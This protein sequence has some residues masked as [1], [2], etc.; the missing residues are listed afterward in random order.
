M[1]NQDQRLRKIWMQTDIPVIFRQERPEPTLVRLPFSLDNYHWLKGEHRRKPDWDKK[2]KCWETPIAWFD[3]LITISLARFNRVYV[4]QA[5]KE[6]QKCAPA[7][8]NAHGFHCECS[9]MGENHGTGQPDGK[10]HEVSETFAFHWGPRHYA[11]RLIAM[12]QNT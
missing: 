3:D 10:W 12:S 11:C 8:W 2:F 4:V 1:E 7:C 9:C 6:Q 5:H